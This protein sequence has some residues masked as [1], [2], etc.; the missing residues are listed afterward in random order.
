MPR[1][2]HHEISDALEEFDLD[3]VPDIT[4]DDEPED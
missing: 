2:S 3:D 4:W 1:V